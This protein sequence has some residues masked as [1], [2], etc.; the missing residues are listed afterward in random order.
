MSSQEMATLKKPAKAGESRN[1]AVLSIFVG[2]GLVPL[3][4]A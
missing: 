3:L 1:Q 4:F 2:C